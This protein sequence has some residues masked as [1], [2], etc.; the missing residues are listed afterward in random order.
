MT[1][2]I[3]DYRPPRIAQFLIIAASILHWLTPLN[4]VYVYANSVVGIVL[5]IAGFCIMIWG[6]WLFKRFN[7]AICPTAMSSFLVTTGIYRLTRNPMYLGMITM[8]LALAIEVGTLPFYAAAA[9]YFVIINAVFC[10]Y[11]EQ[12]LMNIFGEDYSIYKKR[13]GRWI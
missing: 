8:L 5:G 6:W 12:K 10:P 11:E 7:T 4:H 1:V 13:V 2:R 3:I 9:S